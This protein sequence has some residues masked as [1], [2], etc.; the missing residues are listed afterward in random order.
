M[1]RDQNILEYLQNRLSLADKDA[2]ERMMAQDAALAAEVDVMRAV[3]AEL[4][5]GPKH[6]NAD[7]V[8]DRISASI[9]AQAA[10]ANNNR[11]P[12]RQ[13]LKYAAV[14]VLAIAAW[15]VAVVPRISA[16]P[17]GFRTVSETSEAVS[18]QVKFT[19]TTTLVDI[20]A[21]LAP[22][23]GRIIDGPGALGLVRLSFPD[24]SLAEAAR[25][26]LESNATLVE[27][28]AD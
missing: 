26:V 3:Q 18:I 4:T 6:E 8:W 15:Q 11:S 17:E 20:S 14:A 2:F 1:T 10:P 23:D 22:L 24:E 13:M 9:D 25:A 28:V 27:F 5:D 12:W 16:V 7:A 19:E 21:L